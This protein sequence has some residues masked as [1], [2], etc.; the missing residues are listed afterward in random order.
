MM[1][2]VF[3]CVQYTISNIM[4]HLKDELALQLHQL[5]FNQK[6]LSTS[7]SSANSSSLQTE[8]EWELLE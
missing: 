3:I 7:S 5:S 2:S 1:P 4:V 6:H 8:A